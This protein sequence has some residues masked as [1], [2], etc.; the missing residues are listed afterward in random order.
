MPP[1][2]VPSNGAV[3]LFYELH[4]TNLR[5]PMVRL[6]SVTV[7]DQSG[8]ELLRLEAKSLVDDL[9][10][11]GLVAGRDRRDID[12]GSTAVVFIEVISANGR[13]PRSLTHRLTFNISGRESVIDG[14]V[15]PVSPEQAVVISPPLRGNGWIALSGLSNANAPGTPLLS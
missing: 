13:V 3:H 10:R 14:V 6:E 15:V 2:P 12:G 8:R 5:T 7:A 1:T 11:P 4:L 9:W